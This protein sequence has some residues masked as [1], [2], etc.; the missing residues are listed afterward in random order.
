MET[1]WRLLAKYVQ[2]ESTTE[3]TQRLLNWAQEDP[4]HQRL[5]EKVR[6]AW[7][8]SGDVYQAYRPDTQKAWRIIDEKTSESTVVPLPVR[9]ERR[10]SGALGWGWRVAAALAVAVGLVYLV[11][12]L[13]PPGGWGLEEAR[14]DLYETRQLEL[15]DGTTVWLN[16]N[17]TLRYA[18][19]FDDSVRRVYLQG[20]AFFEVAHNERQPFLIESRGARTRVLGTSFN[21]RADSD[22]AVVVTVV[23]G[24]VMLSSQKNEQQRVV[25]QRDEQ[26]RYRAEDQRVYQTSAIPDNT[27]A[28]Q[29][30]RMNFNNQSLAAVARVIEEVYKKRIVIDPAI[31]D[32][33]LTAQFDDQPLGEVLEVIALTLD[34]AYQ[35]TAKEIY[36]RELKK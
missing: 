12:F 23:T 8:T 14:T 24:T 36:F 17:T 32:L 7:E 20:E 31:A 19:P 28:W 4:E 13:A 1:D 26:G 35:E 29:T 22:S 27:L 9:S 33:L 18:E 3:E 34:V 11:M 15:A 2:G 25:L 30:H 6:Q 5:L 10:S 16:E 21:V